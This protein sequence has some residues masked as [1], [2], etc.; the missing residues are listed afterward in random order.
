[1]KKQDKTIKHKDSSLSPRIS[2]RRLTNRH[3]GGSRCSAMVCKLVSR[4]AADHCVHASSAGN[5]TPG[6]GQ[7]SDTLFQ[8]HLKALALHLLHPESLLTAL[9]PQPGEKVK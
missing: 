7:L 3:G 2:L 4:G 9:C 6:E 8:G 5:I 1:M